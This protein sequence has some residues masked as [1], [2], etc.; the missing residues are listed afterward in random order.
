MISLFTQQNR[1]KSIYIYIYMAIA[2]NIFMFGSS[3]NLVAADCSNCSNSWTTD[4]SS[5]FSYGNCVFNIDFSYRD[6][7]TTKELRVNSIQTL[8]SECDTTNKTTIYKYSLMYLL[9]QYYSIFSPIDTWD[10]NTVSIISNPC[11]KNA[12]ENGL[13]EFC[14]DTLCQNIK[15]N[16][17]GSGKFVEIIGSNTFSKNY[18]GSPCGIVSPC[19]QELLE[20]FYTIPPG[21]LYPQLSSN[22]LDNNNCDDPCYW[23]LEGNDNVDD[24][25][26]FLGTINEQD[27]RMKTN[28]IERLRIFSD[29][30]GFYS[31]EGRKPYNVHNGEDRFLDE[32]DKFDFMFNNGIV[33]GNS[34][35]W[36]LNDG[37]SSDANRTPEQDGSVTLMPHKSGESYH[38]YN[39][40][41]FG[42]GI[43]GGR[44]PG[45]NWIADGVTV[46]G[47]DGKAFGTN[48]NAN[49][50]PAYGSTNILT[51]VSWGRKVGIGMVPQ[52][53]GSY[54]FDNA[55]NWNTSTLWGAAGPEGMLT[56][57]DTYWHWLDYVE[58][59]WEL[60]GGNSVILRLERRENI[61]PKPNNTNYTLISAGHDTGESFIVRADSS[62][63]IGTQETG[64]RVYIKSGGN[65]DATF[66]L[67]VKNSDNTNLLS[68]RDDAKIGINTTSFDALLSLKGLGNDDETFA[69]IAKN[70]DNTNLFSIRD[71]GNVGINNSTPNAS[72]AIKSYGTTT[73]LALDVTNSSSS[74][75]LQIK[76]NGNIGIG[77]V[78]GTAKLTLKGQGSTSSTESINIQN[79][80]SN[81]LFKIKDNGQTIIGEETITTG[82]HTDFKLSVDGKIVAQEIIT[83]ETGWADH[84]FK[85]DYKLL[86]LL[87]LEKKI[88]ASGH[89]PGIP[90]EAE[91]K[92]N[93]V[94]INEMQV[95]MLEKIEELTL[96]MIEL[97]KENEKLKSKISQIEGER[98]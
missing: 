96:Y 84:V 74:N 11:I 56:V 52:K 53:S 76:D 37:T 50:Q 43:S 41:G 62:I 82:D 47:Y 21:P 13:I 83:T 3:P 95:K 90:S 12:D 77:L 38:L 60:W 88:Q 26:H 1:S 32:T 75:L 46:D 24:Y 63:S 2:F 34:Q 71:D 80:S 98:K 86:S 65:N 35:S 15:Y 9:S 33:V 4:I 51:A 42:F 8:T 68:I 85:P 40:L 61:I 87:E 22:P 81:E 54:V 17:T 5:T 78:S 73:G 79:S 36:W 29:G 19:G 58:D 31:N 70:S 72:L 59:E 94:S 67:K 49:Q 89:L 27:L 66:A 7:D 97:Q 39:A 57:S 25:Y 20:F 30:K 64:A 18:M 6:C 28:D 55:P 93:G 23:K 14:D 48:A 91:V 10:T 45:T 16:L 92:Q 44:Y 69:F